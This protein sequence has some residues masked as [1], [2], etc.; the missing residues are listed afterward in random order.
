MGQDSD[1]MSLAM[2]INFVRLDQFF[3]GATRCI[4]ETFHDKSHEKIHS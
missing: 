2:Y 3:Q 1:T 4:N